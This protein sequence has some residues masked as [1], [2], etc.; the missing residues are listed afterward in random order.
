MW[1]KYHQEKTLE[2]ICPS[3]PTY[4][5]QYNDDD[6]NDNLTNLRFASHL[7]V[8]QRGGDGGG[9][10]SGGGQLRP[11][12]GGR[13]LGASEHGVPVRFVFIF[14]CLFLFFFIL[15]FGFFK[16]GNFL[17]FWCVFFRW[18]VGVVV[19]P[20]KGENVFVL[21]EK[22]ESLVYVSCGILAP[23]AFA[24]SMTKLPLRRYC[25]ELSGL[26]RSC[27]CSKKIHHSISKIKIDDVCS[28]GNFLIQYFWIFEFINLSIF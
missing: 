25:G 24:P 15:R 14:H 28:F 11:R 4:P 5:K 10:G 26:F 6:Y 23:S 16:G 2:F 13:G 27:S 21:V 12:A 8:R 1:S 3:A 18:I 9:G 20:R 22:R 19:A 7:L 17:R